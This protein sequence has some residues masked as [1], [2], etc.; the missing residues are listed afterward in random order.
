MLNG[1]FDVWGLLGSHLDWMLMKRALDAASRDSSARRRRLTA[2]KARESG[3]VPSWDAAQVGGRGVEAKQ[4][5]VKV[6]VCRVAEGTKGKSPPKPQ[7]MVMAIITRRKLRKYSFNLLLFFILFLIFVDFDIEQNANQM[8]DADAGHTLRRR[9]QEIWN[10]RE[11]VVPTY[12]ERSRAIWDEASDVPV[13]IIQRHVPGRTGSNYTKGAHIRAPLGWTFFD[14]LYVYK[15]T[16]YIVTNTSAHIPDVR[17][18]ISAGRPL[19]DE[20]GDHLRREPTERHMK[21]ISPDAVTKEFGRFAKRVE[22]TSVRTFGPQFIAGLVLP[23][24]RSVHCK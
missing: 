19:L 1:L 13:T 4:R 22:G 3:S 12:Y 6:R 18:M 5:R 9:I 14:N 8:T 24:I 17:M 20:H 7:R 23:L 2:R 11:E 21:I 15:G 16:V 10:Q